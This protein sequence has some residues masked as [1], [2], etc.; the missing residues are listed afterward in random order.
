MG[1]M[2]TQSWYSDHE[3]CLPE[4][5]RESDEVAMYELHKML[6]QLVHCQLLT[7]GRGTT[8]P[9]VSSNRSIEQ[10]S[11]K[12]KYNWNNVKDTQLRTD[13]VMMNS[14]YLKLFNISQAS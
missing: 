11:I 10:T 5:S 4:I 1:A 6:L 13:N 12:N 7:D 8:F 14:K 2:Y 3:S 9:P